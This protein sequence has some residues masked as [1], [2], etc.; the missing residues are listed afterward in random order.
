MRHAHGLKLFTAN[1]NRFHGLP[2]ADAL[3]FNQSQY[4]E[5]L[6]RKEDFV[7]MGRSADVILKN[8]GI[9]HISIFITAPFES[10]VK[11]LME[12]HELSFK[13]AAKLVKREDKAHEHFYHRYTGFK[14]GSAVHYDLCINSA[15]YGIHESEEL[16]I[17]VIKARLRED[18][19]ALATRHQE[20]VEKADAEL[21]ARRAEQ[22]ADGI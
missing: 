20:F 2:T 10:R 4:I 8:A 14:W 22:T 19:Q 17:R 3:F 6:A 15:S 7:V 9:P 18:L 21:L 16:I 5:E 11:R 12:M 1:F 13:E